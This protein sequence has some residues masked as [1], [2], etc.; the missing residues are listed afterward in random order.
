MDPARLV[1]GLERRVGRKGLEVYDISFQVKGERNVLEEVG[2]FGRES[3]S[4]GMRR[5]LGIRNELSFGLDQL[6][7]S[8]IAMEPLMIDA[9][10]VTLGNPFYLR[11]GNADLWTVRKAGKRLKRWALLLGIACLTGREAMCVDHA[12]ELLFAF[13]SL[14]LRKMIAGLPN[15]V[16]TSTHLPVEEKHQLSERVLSVVEDYFGAIRKEVT[17]ELLTIVPVGGSELSVDPWAWRRDDDLDSRRRF[18]FANYWN[19]FEFLRPLIYNVLLVAIPSDNDKKDHE[20][21]KLAE[22]FA[23]TIETLDQLQRVARVFR[24]ENIGVVRR[25]GTALST[26]AQEE[27]AIPPHQPQTTT[28]PTS[29]PTSAPSPA[30]RWTKSTLLTQESAALFLSGLDLLQPFNGRAGV[31]WVNPFEVLHAHDSIRPVFRNGSTVQDA[32]DNL[33]QEEL[34]HDAA[35]SSKMIEEGPH[36]RPLSAGPRSLWNFPRVHVTVVPEGVPQDDVLWNIHSRRFLTHANRR[37]WVFQEV[38][39]QSGGSIFERIP[40]LVTERAV[41]AWKVTRRPGQFRAPLRAPFETAGQFRSR[42]FGTRYGGPPGVTECHPHPKPPP[43][44]VWS[45]PVVHDSR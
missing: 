44:P 7:V 31:L 16:L 8:L 39:V 34:H 13:V 43:P 35:K 18:Y 3:I 33:S 24:T 26:T 10:V 11:R 9:L 32:V 20:K 15:L 1:L 40:V 45:S 28:A 4:I 5:G 29:A 25:L 17:E 19:V 41:P 14:S 38:L 37:L 21:E 36:H 12:P 30:Q 2:S 23:D 42:I 6:P 22:F 27:H